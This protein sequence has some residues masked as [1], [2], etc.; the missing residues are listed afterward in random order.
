MSHVSSFQ[1]DAL[2]WVMVRLGFVFGYE[3]WVMVGIMVWVMLSAGLVYQSL[4]DTKAVH[5]QKIHNYRQ[6]N[7]V[8]AV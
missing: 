4:S 1:F 7:R 5:E 2:T 3:F 6:N 8:Q